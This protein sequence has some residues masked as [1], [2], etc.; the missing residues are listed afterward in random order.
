MSVSFGAFQAALNGMKAHQRSFDKAA[1]KLV[2][3]TLQPSPAQL[4]ASGGRALVEAGAADGAGR[5]AGAMV[6]MITVQNAYLASTRAL[7]VAHE[8]LKGV[9]EGIDA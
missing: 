7:E 3:A 4:D 1:N 6:D 2:K 5:M 9:L 8:T